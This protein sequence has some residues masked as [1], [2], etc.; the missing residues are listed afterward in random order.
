MP[1][2]TIA[3]PT[4]AKRVVAGVVAIYVRPSGGK[5]QTLGAIRATE[6]MI[7][8]Y[9]ESDSKRKNKSIQSNTVTGKA[10]MMQCSITE[11]ELLDSLVD[12]TNSFLFKL[13]DAGA[14]PVAAAVTE[15]W[16]LFTAAQLG[17]KPKIVL[18]GDV[19]Q[20]A[21]IEL[22]FAGSLLDSE[23]DAAVKASIDDNDFESSADAGTFHAIGTYTAALDGG[24][25]TPTN[26][27]SCGI[28][29]LTLADT[30]GA[31]QT[32]G[33]INSPTI[34][35]EYLSEIDTD[36]LK[37]HRCYAVNV[38]LEYHWKQT[39]AVNLLNLDDFFD[40]EID[41]VVTM[42][43][44]LALTLTNQVGGG[45]RFESLGDYERTRSIVIK[46]EGSVRISDI[47]GIFA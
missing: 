28:S 43:N 27:K 3:T 16:M 24:G 41:A 39:D 46:H 18:S 14:I 36:S 15:G 12:G 10:T 44:G 25:P 9:T 21:R 19:E 31:A 33:P 38:N 34:E 7:S 42:K 13:A 47:D 6:L 23:L 2:P 30:G 26:I 20:N 40:V 11:I 8:G 29:A 22:E 37:V 17:V 4:N 5:Y 45:A 32:L 35:F 1:F